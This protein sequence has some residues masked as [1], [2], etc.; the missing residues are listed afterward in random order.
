MLR[1]A[2]V[3]AVV[4]IVLVS[5]FVLAASKVNVSTWGFNLD[6]LDKN[7]SV[8]FEKEYGISVVRDLGN[9]SVR[10]TKLLAQKKNP[11][12]DVVQFADYYAALAK[13]D[14]VFEPIDVSRLKNYGDL[15]DF[16]RDPVGG[17]YAIAYAVSGYGIVYRTD[18]IKEPVTSWKDFWRPDLAGHI[19]LPDLTITQGPAFMMHIN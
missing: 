13:E 15:Y 19:S 9:N 16:A 10:Y 6:L 18:L 2:A 7:I 8:P 4:I 12:I 14:D 3:I 5:T 11:V 17:N 1:K